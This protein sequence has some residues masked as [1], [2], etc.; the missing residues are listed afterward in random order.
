MTPRVNPRENAIRNLMKPA[1]DGYLPVPE[2]SVYNPPD[3]FNPTIEPPDG[4]FDYLA[5][6]ENGIDYNEVVSY[7]NAPVTTGSQK[8]NN[9]LIPIGVD[10]VEPGRGWGANTNTNPDGCDGSYDGFCGRGKS[11]DCLLSAHN[12]HRGGL[13]FDSY[14]GW[15]IFTVPNVKKGL[16]FTR[17]EWW[18][19]AGQHNPRTDGWVTENNATAR[20]L[21]DSTQMQEANRMEP[22]EVS[23]V[24][25]DFDDHMW[26]DDLSNSTLAKKRR[27]GEPVLPEGQMERHLGGQ[28]ICATA[29]FEI[30]FNGKI[31]SFNKAQYEAY[32]KVFQRVVPII[33]IVDDEEF[34]KGEPHDVEFG[35]RLTGCDKKTS[36]FQLSNIYWA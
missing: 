7:D 31:R 23:H 34:T 36:A 9:K 18:Y 19:N 35:L 13:I 4:A 1:S 2:E 21:A 12:D 32:N 5:V 22:S 17:I 26:I 30:A 33:T 15:G 8:T 25:T 29:K 16:I 3:V 27:L 11:N 20:R 14:S 6:V 10:G 28:E 24:E